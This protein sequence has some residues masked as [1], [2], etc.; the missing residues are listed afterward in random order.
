MPALVVVMIALMMVEHGVAQPSNNDTDTNIPLRFYCGSNDA[1]SPTSFSRNLDSTF[2]QLKSR[3]SNDDGVYYARAQNLENGDAVYGVAQCRNYLSATQCLA[4]FDVAVSAVEP[5]GSAN[6][7]NVFLDNCFLRR[8]VLTFVFLTSKYENYDEFYDDPEGSLDVAVAPLGICGNQS[9]SQPITVFNQAVQELLSDIQIATPRTSDFYIA[10][11]RQVASGNATVYAIGQCVANASRAICKKCLS[12]AYNNLYSCLPADE[13]RAINVG[14]FMRYSEF[15]FFR[16][17]QT[18][19]ITP[20]LGE[21]S[22]SK[23]RIIIGVTSIAGLFLLILVAI[24]LW[25]SRWRKSKDIEK[26]TSELQG[27]KSYSYRDLK[28]AT[29]NFSEEHLVG[30]GGFGEV[31]KATVDGGVVVAIKKLHVGS[32]AKKEFEN[33]IKLISNVRHRNLIQQLGWCIDGPELLLVLEYMPHGSLDKFLWG[34]KRGLLNWKQRSDVILGIAKGLAHLH[35]EFHVKIIHRDIKSSNILL[36]N[37]FQPKIA[38]FGLARFQPE[39]ETHVST[40]FAGT[41]G[42]TAPEY[43]NRGH[44]SEKVDVH[45]FGIVALEVI[46]GRRCSDVDYNGPQM[47]YLLDQA[48]QLYEKG[49]HVKLIDESV[50][51]NAFEEEN[52]RKMVEIALMCT[53]SPPSLRPSMSEVVLMISSGSMMGQL[54]QISRPTFIDA[55]RRIHIVMV[56]KDN[57]SGARMDSGYF[58]D[59]VSGRI[60]ELSAVQKKDEIRELDATTRFLF[61]LPFWSIVDLKTS[62]TIIEDISLG[63][64]PLIKQLSFHFSEMGE[65]APKPITSLRRSCWIS[66][67]VVMVFIAMAEQVNSQSIDGSNT[68]LR[69]YCRSYDVGNGEVYLN[70]L[71]TTLSSLRQ[72]LSNP[73]VYYAFAE[74]RDNDDYVYSFALCREYLSTSRCLACF[75]SAV[76]DTKACRIADGG[77]IIYDDCSIRYENFGQMFNNPAV[78]LDNDATPR[79]V[80]GNEST[81]Q[82]ITSFNQV[83]QELLSDIRFATPR[84]SDFYVASTRQVSTS[85]ANATVYAI[86]QCVQNTSQ[87]ICQSCLTTAYNNLRGCLPNT[88]GRSI[89]FF[90]FMRY[91]VAP[92]FLNNQT[93]NIVPFLSEGRPLYFN[94][95]VADFQLQLLNLFYNQ[96][97]K[98]RFM[99]VLWHAMMSS[100]TLAAT[101]TKSGLI[102]GVSGGVGLFLLTLAL[103]IWYRRKKKSKTVGEDESGLQG[104]KSY[105]Y[106]DLR[107]AT[108][109]FD[110]EYRVG[111]GGFGE[112]FKAIIDDE[113]VV[114]VKRLHVGYGNAKLE[115]DNEVKLLGSVQ[116]R[117]LVRQLGWCSEGPELLLVLE[118]MPQ[119]SL[120]N[121]LWGKLVLHKDIKSNNIL[122]DDDFQPKIADFGLARLQAEDQTHVSTKLAG[123]L[124][125]MAP[126]YA[127][128]GHLSENVDTYSFGIVALEIISGRRCTDE[129][130]SG[131]DTAHLIEHAWQLY[132]KGMHIQLIDEVIGKEEYQE[133]NVLKTIEIAL[134][135]TQSPASLRPSMSEVVLMLSSGQSLGPRQLIKPTFIDSHRV[136]H[137]GAKRLQNK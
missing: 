22:S 35:E 106:Q 122:L 120:D 102:G 59:F 45:S 109:N 18:I 126:E 15:P 40:R 12:T 104:A 9:T 1:M 27:A 129:N 83:V 51:P 5:C 67:M 3:L 17:N 61:A 21:G 16:D 107:I 65:K 79:G 133:A 130:F 127:T 68:L 46:S 131:P 124:G 47:E 117:N 86:A 78:I 82:P 31:F 44:L 53:Q 58:V 23:Y 54:R 112:V 90:C 94:T 80:C 76:N 93:T 74:N 39:D 116:H 73:Q 97:S 28:L 24:S 96:C 6:G 121:F 70:N 132:E 2:S 111:K 108:H 62:D 49:T 19:N 64:P 69:R 29:N 87:A 48:W 84:T 100:R 42:Y 134:M 92:F 63:L 34:E 43:A 72:Q 8:V 135:C 91:S 81:S 7:A 66:G 38:D 98:E 52:V 20:F 114:A 13:A 11:T 60:R 14:C 105:S 113:N 118:Y 25:Y 95:L 125:Y 137:I 57:R 41:M 123:T 37:D 33:E 101:S 10:S 26:D 115:F 136:V 4:C 89:D 55:H 71:N 36:D 75:D 128:H 119:G 103:W 85:N 99:T 50:D 56:V 30:K 77:N 32:R 88:E 110:E